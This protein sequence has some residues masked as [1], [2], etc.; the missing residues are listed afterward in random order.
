M[1][2]QVKD[3]NGFPEQAFMQ[4][5]QLFNQMGHWMEWSKRHE[6][7]ENDKDGVRYFIKESQHLALIY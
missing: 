3:I 7:R 6:N 2:D 5:D 4:H 1:E